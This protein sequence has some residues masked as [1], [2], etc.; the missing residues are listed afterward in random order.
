MDTILPAELVEAARRVVAANIAAG[1]RVSLAESCTGGLV[2]AALTEIAGCSEMFERSYVTYSNEAKTEMLRVSADVIDTFGA[3]SVATAWS[4]AQGALA[5]S[6]AD[7]AVAI[8]GVA[9]PEG[10]TSKKP[11][12]TVVFARAERGADP[13]GPVGR[14]PLN[15][16]PP[17]AVHRL[18][19]QPDVAQHRHAAR[20]QERDRGRH[21]DAAFELHGGAPGLGHH[22]GGR[23][24]GLL[25]RA[26]VGA[27]REIDHHQ[28]VFRAPHH[29]LAMRDHHVEGDAQRGRQAV[30]DHAQR[31][32]HQDHV[33]M[34]VEQPRHR[35][36]ISGQGH[37]G[38]L[39]LARGDVADRDRPGRAHG[40][41]GRV[42]AS[43]ATIPSHSASSAPRATGRPARAYQ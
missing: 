17:Q 7:V 37:D 38:H 6:G 28:R 14:P 24:E 2:A 15:P 42:S 16:E 29:G 23:R 1:R 10:G 36:R 33:A 34:G 19:H 3:V 8:T 30:H 25:G 35:G 5:A 11:V 18:R 27:E 4:M 12:G 31:I 40:A 26:L 9:G 39:A 13:V 21:G 20:G 43:T 41:H 32:A 22:A